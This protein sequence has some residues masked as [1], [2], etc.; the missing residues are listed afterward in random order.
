MLLP[1]ECRMK[2][3]RLGEVKGQRCRQQRNT[4]QIVRR[5]QPDVERDGRG[6]LLTLPHSTSLY[7]TNPHLSSARPSLSLSLARP[8]NRQPATLQHRIGF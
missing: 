5:E 8:H 2:A 7:L 4:Q 3:S 6:Q 1:E